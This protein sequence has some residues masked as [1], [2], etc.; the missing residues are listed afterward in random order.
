MKLNKHIYIYIY[1]FS[2]FFY[3]F[4]CASKVEKKSNS[5]TK[6]DSI[7]RT[8][9]W[10]ERIKMEDSINYHMW[11]NDKFSVL[12]KKTLYNNDSSVFYKYL[13][14]SIGESGFLFSNNDYYKILLSPN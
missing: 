7:H 1:F 2:V 6:T 4:S 14:D 5:N 3:L 13:G 10:N 8:L 11:K 9:T 12:N